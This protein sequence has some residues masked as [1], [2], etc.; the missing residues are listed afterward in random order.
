MQTVEDQA[1]KVEKEANTLATP[2]QLR[3]RFHSS[4]FSLSDLELQEELP[5]LLEKGL[6]MTEP[7]RQYWM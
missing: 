4:A 1:V 5:L 3:G 6:G 2:H 7:G